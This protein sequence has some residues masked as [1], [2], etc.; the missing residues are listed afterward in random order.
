MNNY[1]YE[2]E[3]NPAKVDKILKRTYSGETPDE[4]FGTH[5]RTD[6]LVEDL[7]SGAA[8]RVPDPVERER[9]RDEEEA[10]IFH[11]ELEKMG[12]K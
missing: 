8:Y 3:G 10:K 12:L 11:E 5:H 7:M 6:Q 1:D 9:I 2:H 4:I